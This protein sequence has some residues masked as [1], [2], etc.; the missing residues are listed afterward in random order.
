[1]QLPGQGA[2][3]PHTPL[4]LLQSAGLA[5]AVPH[6][7]WSLL[8]PPGVVFTA[9]HSHRSSCIPWHKCSRRATCLATA[10]AFIHKQ[11]LWVPLPAHALQSL[12]DP[13]RRTM[14]N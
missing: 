4:V 13:L 1:M 12:L 8:H 5:A 7:P 2:A 3:A 14:A 9:A 6:T 11:L 10:K